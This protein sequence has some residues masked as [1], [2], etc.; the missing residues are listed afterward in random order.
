MRQVTLYGKGGKTRRVLLS[1]STWAVVDA[2]RQREAAEGY[3]EPDGP[4][5]RSRK[6]DDDGSARPLT[7]Q[8]LWRVVKG[9]ATRAGLPEAVSPHFFRHA[10]AS[11]ALD[12]PLR[13]RPARRL[14]GALPRRVS[15]W[16]NPSKVTIYV[17]AHPRWHP[18]SSHRPQPLASRGGTLSEEVAQIGS[19]GGVFVRDRAVVFCPPPLDVCSYEMSRPTTRLCQH[20]LCSMR[21]S[22]IAR[23]DRQSATASCSRGSADW[24]V[25][26][27]LNGL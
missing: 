22:A 8:Q 7:R 3:A 10:H 18:T 4:V 11:H 6:A 2:H 17:E 9:L 16:V 1:P 25:G 27:R 20:V 14:V 19:A 21:L 13:T 5:L 26:N 15:G 12:E 23:A 24:D